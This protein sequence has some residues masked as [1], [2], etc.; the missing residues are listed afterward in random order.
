MTATLTHI[1]G[2][3]LLAFLLGYGV[4]FVFRSYVKIIQGLTTLE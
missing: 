3:G 2:Y 4:G 1:A